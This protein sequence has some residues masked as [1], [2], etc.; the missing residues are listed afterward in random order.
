MRQVGIDYV[1]IGDVL[2]RPIFAADGQVL[3]G[4]GVVLSAGYI[5]KLRNLGMTA[6]YVRDERFS[7]IE[8]RDVVT[9]ETRRKVLRGLK[10]STDMIRSGKNFE[11]KKLK[12]SVHQVIEEV[13]ANHRVLISFPD[14]RTNE[15]QLMAHSVQVCVLSTLLG[16]ACGLDR[17]RLADLATG[18]LLHDVGITLLPKEIAAK[19][20]LKMTEDERKC[21]N[22]HT[23]KGFELL[24][25]NGNINLLSAHVTYQHHEH[26]DGTGYPR[27]IAGE[28]IHLFGRITAVCDLYDNLVNGGLEGRNLLPHEACEYLMAQAGSRLDVELVR[29]FLKSIAAY[30][31]GSSVRLSTGEVGVVVD[32]NSSMPMRPVIRVLEERSRVI[33]P[34]EYNLITEKTVFIEEVFR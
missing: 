18:A 19:S 16:I 11:S 27:G 10:D 28:E 31:T 21:F 20:F 34:I 22:E 12:D 17:F 25:K 2:E 5:S 4:R 15:N 6:L 33:E 23:T 32:Q 30:P 1:N 26:V 3:L 13:T 9:E 29:L 14:I 8:I 7:D 24:R